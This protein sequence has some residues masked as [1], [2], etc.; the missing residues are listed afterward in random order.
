M[1]INEVFIPYKYVLNNNKLIL[2]STKSSNDT[3]NNINKLINNE[4]STT[5]STIEIGISSSNSYS[6]V[7]SPMSEPHN[8]KI[9]EDI[10]YSKPR[11]I[12]ITSDEYPTLVY[13]QNNNIKTFANRI[14]TSL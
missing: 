11:N 12:S 6:T 9:Y 5:S 8:R 10:T 7:H 4:I 1:I 3:L 2:F 14:N 13:I